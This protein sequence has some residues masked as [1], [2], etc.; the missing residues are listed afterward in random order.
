MIGVR[1][2]YSSTADVET[3]GS[4]SVTPSELEKFAR[5][6]DS[7][8]DPQGP[9]KYLHTMNRTRTQFIRSHLAD[10]SRLPR[11]ETLGRAWIRGRRVVDIGCG[12]G[13]ASESLARLGM[14]V[15][16]VDAARENVEM[17]RIHAQRDPALARNLEY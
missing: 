13:L 15:L 8:W 7:W 1:R 2:N 9:F 3:R 6:S 14:Q 4:H 5:V 10:L 16:G 12:G 17:A 11:Q